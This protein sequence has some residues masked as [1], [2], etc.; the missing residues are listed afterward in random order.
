MTSES[1]FPGQSEPAG[2]PG[3]AERFREYAVWKPP[4]SAVRQD[5]SYQQQKPPSTRRSTPVQ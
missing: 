4:N 3:P 1:P 2:F 5:A